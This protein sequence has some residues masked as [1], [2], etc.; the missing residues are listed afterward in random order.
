MKL[1]HV[2]ILVCAVAICGG[3]GLYLA[4]LNAPRPTDLD[5]ADSPRSEGGQD[6]AENDAETRNVHAQGRL[7]PASGV[8]NLAALPGERVAMVVAKEG[9]EYDQ[10]AVLLELES[11]QLYQVEYDLAKQRTSSGGEIYKVE[12]ALAD[13]R[14]K[15]AQLGLQ[16]A[17]LKQQ[18]VLGQS[19]ELVLGESQADQTKIDLERL[20]GLANNPRTDPFISK[21]QVEHQELLQE[22]AYSDWEMGKTN[23]DLAKQTAEVAVSVAENNVE[24]AALAIR[25]INASNPQA[26]NLLAEGAAERRLN[27]SDVRAPIAG[28]VLRI[29]VRQGERAA[30]APVIQF[31]DTRNMICKAEV[32]DSMRQFIRVG[33][34]VDLTSPAI[35]RTLTGK[36]R[37]IGVIVG[38]P[39]F[40]NPN[41][42]ARQDRHTVQ[43]E[44]ELD[45]AAQAD[46]REY[47]HLLVDVVIKASGSLPAAPPEKAR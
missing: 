46:A 1:H 8:I 31:A 34:P 39:D 35:H 15:A 21:Q 40:P 29:M 25:Q 10:D 36:V 27:S 23:F 4:S 38:D 17:A 30:N 2:L 44:I 13:A 37:K 19:R 43:V 42:L 26:A 45:P 41:P 14:L 5:S 16:Q 3:G 24:M 33:D 11:K 6:A 7:E 47:I 9:Q 22:K 18:E 12:L 20:Q 28:R 32:Y